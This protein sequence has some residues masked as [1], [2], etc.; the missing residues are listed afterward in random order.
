MHLHTLL[1]MHGEDMA[2]Q[3]YAFEVLL[4]EMSLLFLLEVCLLYIVLLLVCYISVVLYEI[5]I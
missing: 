4:E 1:G 5:A 3:L 2:S